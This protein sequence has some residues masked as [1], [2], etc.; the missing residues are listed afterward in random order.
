MSRKSEVNP[1]CT[2]SAAGYFT[3]AYFGARLKKGLVSAG[4][5]I[6][7]WGVAHIASAG[8]YWDFPPLPEPYQYGDLLIDRTSTKNQVKPVFFSHWSHR[9][10]YACRVCHFE[11]DFAFKVNK[12]EMTEEDNRN[13]L[14]C[15][16]CHDGKQ[17]FGHTEG[18]CEKC[19][20]GENI[21][22]HDKFNLLARQLPKTEYGNKIDWVGAVRSKRITPRYS[23]F[24]EDEIPMAF[25]KDLELAAEWSFVPPAFFPH[26]AHTPWLDCA[27]CHPDIFNIKK[28]TTKHFSMKYILEERFCGVCHLK[29]AFP[30]N[31]CTGCHPKIKGK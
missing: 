25:K 8:Q 20:A 17:V 26:A 3:S 12:T 18:N 5:F 29:I 22:S 30:L 10:K 28:K 14:F 31:N 1:P 6:V 2:R 11:L 15:G 24:N 27:N 9:A 19:H 16:A 23:I 13:G 7:F 4:I 21:S